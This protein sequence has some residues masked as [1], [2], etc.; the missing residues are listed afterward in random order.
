MQKN[1]ETL[2]DLGRTAREDSAALKRLT[3]QTRRDSRSTKILTF[4]ALLYLPA[5]LVAVSKQ[6]EVLFG[7][8]VRSFVNVV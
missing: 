4:V 8:H 3:E 6:D 7:I 1:T 2:A 5:S